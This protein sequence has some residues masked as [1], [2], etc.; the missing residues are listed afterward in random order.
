[1][2]I[3]RSLPSLRVLAALLPMAALAACATDGTSPTTRP[4]PTASAAP[5][6]SRP[7]VAPDEATTYGLFLA[8]R[9]AMAQGAAGDAAAYFGAAA[10]SG[11]GGPGDGGAGLISERAF[12]AALMA[13]DVRKAATLAPAAGDANADPEKARLGALVRGVE[14]LAEDNG[15]QA[16]AILKGPEVGYPHKAAASLVIPWAAAAAGDVDGSVIHTVLPGDP[17]DQFYA[18]LS[19]ARLF[20]RAKRYDEAETH[21]K[22]LIAAGDP[23]AM[24]SQSYGA[25]LERRKRAADAVAVYQAALNRFPDSADLQDAL[26]RAKAHKSPPP[27]LSIKEGASEALIAPAAALMVQHQSEYALAYLHLALRLNP[28]QD[29]AWMLAGDCLNAMGDSDGAREAYARLKPGSDRYITA[30]NKMAWTY[31]NGDDHAGALK[32]ARETLSASPENQEAAVNLA[33]LLR[34]NEQYEDS[35]KI[36]DKVIAAQG[37]HV[38]WRLLYARAASLE[39]AGHWQDAERDLQTALKQRPDEPELLNF[40]A[41]SWIDRGERLQEALGMVQKAVDANPQSGAM[42]DSLGWAYFRLGDFKTAVAKLE[43]AVVLEPA[44]PDVNNHL[45]DAYWRVGRKTEADY[46]WRRVLIL[47]PSAKLKAEVETKLK[48]GLDGVGPAAVASQ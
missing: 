9:E 45:G 28:G 23:G 4:T 25:M 20:E 39:E 27:M 13:G 35:A 19:Q 1:M 18:N 40:L 11:G 21:Y 30:R 41:Y 32:L 7:S 2:P 16:L 3:A 26:A 31:Q 47:Q 17:I 37:D 10:Q 8:G 15:K 36:L 29:E 34:A 44:D 42:L 46:Q 14:A 5:A 43:D 48:S 38:D 22:A 12:F 33:D 24:A 6:P